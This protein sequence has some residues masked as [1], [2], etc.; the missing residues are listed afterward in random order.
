MGRGELKNPFI[1]TGNPRENGYVESF[2]RKLRDGLLNGDLFLTLDQG[3]WVIAAFVTSPCQI[4]MFVTFVVVLAEER[5]LLVTAGV[6]VGD[7][8]KDFLAR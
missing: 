2:N 5:V 1:R 3:R 7:E 4:L 6:D 8:I